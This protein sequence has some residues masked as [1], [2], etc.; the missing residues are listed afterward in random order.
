[1][2][3]ITYFIDILTLFDETYAGIANVNYQLAKYFY[4]HHGENT[5]FFHFDKI[6]KKEIVNLLIQNRTGKGLRALSESGEMYETTLGSYLKHIKTKT[7]GIF[8]HVKSFKNL[9]DYEVQMIYDLTALLTPEFHYQ[10]T[11]NWHV[12]RIEK[13]LESNSL[14]VCISNSTKEDLVSYL[15]FPEEKTLVSYLGCQHGLREAEPYKNILQELGNRVEKFVL[16]LGTVEPRKNVEMVFALLE[17]NLQ[18][19]NEYKFIFLGRD[20]GKDGWGETFKERLSKVKIEKNLKSNKIKHFDYVTEEEKNILLMTAEF[21]I[22]P[23]FYEGFGLPILEALSV[24]CPVLA[25]ISSSIPEVGEDSIY[26]FDPCNIGSFEDTF[27]RLTDDLKLHRERIVE[28]CLKQSSKFTWEKFFERIVNRIED[29]LKNLHSIKVETKSVFSNIDR[30]LQILLIKLD[31]RGDF[32]LS[33]P[34][35]MK[36]MEK[37]KNA[38]I[39]IIVGDWNVSLARRLN[40]FRNIYVY[41]FYATKS[42]LLPEEK[43]RE[44]KELLKSLPQYDIAIDLR[45]PYETRFLLAKAPASMKVGYKSFSDYDKA[46]DVCLESEMDEKGKMIENNRLSVSLQLIKL[47]DSIPFGMLNLPNFIEYKPIGKQIAI[48]PGAGVDSREWPLEYYTRITREILQ[49]G[50]VDKVNIY[51]STFEKGLAK[52]FTNIQDV[53][54]LIGLGFDEMLESLVTNRLVIANNSFAPHICSY[55]GIPSIAIYSGVETICEWGPPFGSVTIIYSDVPCL[56]CH[57]IAKNCPY[58]LICLKQI[59]PEY[60]L[61]II[62]KQLSEEIHFNQT[63]SFIYGNGIVNFCD[64]KFG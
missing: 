45:R 36:L 9:F 64:T 15:A 3:K 39:D 57:D 50:W 18:L 27:Y 34:A 6:V 22:Y 60:V 2:N 44:E 31:H 11:L 58:D 5:Q 14:C 25:S 46:I 12:P 29:D 51:L 32:I 17:N 26:Y 23:S 24:G 63:T 48:F 38:D 7:I 55:L 35:I 54:I 43:I 53:N 49:R 8:Q 37:F 4:Q 33:I 1:M 56:P 21:M 42:S 30:K 16:I 40:V 19:L 59:T 13:D 41:N 62:E 28:H 52:P 20:A 47:I 10:E 61:N